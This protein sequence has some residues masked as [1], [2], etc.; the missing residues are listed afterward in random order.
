M[1]DAHVHAVDF[2][3]D[4]GD[5]SALLGCMDEADVDAAVVF[6]LAYKK[7]WS[8]LEPQRPAYYLDDEASCYPWVATDEAVAR[9]V[10]RADRPDRLAATVCG[11]EPTDLDAPRRVDRLLT[12]GP[13]V[14]VGEL[15]LRH[16]R[17][18]THVLGERARAE[19][20]AVVG[21][22]DVCARHGVPVAIHNNGGSTGQ[23]ATA[24]VDEMEFLL[25]RRGDVDVVW[26]HAGISGEGVGRSP[27]DIDA[28]LGRHPRLHIDL[29]WSATEALADPDEIDAE[30]LEVVAGHPLR[31]VWG[32]DSVGHFEDLPSKAA[33][34]RRFLDQLPPQ[35]R[36]DVASANARRLWFDR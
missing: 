4:T 20:E 33:T 8:R 36:T 31:F 24:Y 34:F 23:G 2:L 15:L 18:S 10:E 3:Q 5:P 25:G 11:I 29:S 30:W 35:A 28:L 21:I 13:F 16:G 9:F 17:L 22:V 32:S 7:K 26:C 14:G 6:G 27:E 19:H 12:E 1:I